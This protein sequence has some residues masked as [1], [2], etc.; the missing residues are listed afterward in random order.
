MHHQLNLAGQGDDVRRGADRTHGRGGIDGSIRPGT[1]IPDTVLAADMHGSLLAELAPL[2][3]SMVPLAMSIM[4]ST[5]KANK[6]HPH[7]RVSTP[8]SGSAS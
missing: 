2:N 8:P 1:A 6:Q 7:D 5:T 3:R 4:E